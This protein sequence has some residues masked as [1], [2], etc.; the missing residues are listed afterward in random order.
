MNQDFMAF[1]DAHLAFFRAPAERLAEHIAH[2]DHAHG[3]TG[4]AGDIKA[5]HRI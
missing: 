5:R 2:I 3:R 1:I 4:H